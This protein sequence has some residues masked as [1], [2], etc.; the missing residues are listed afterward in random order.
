MDKRYAVRAERCDHRAAPEEIYRTLERITAPLTRSWERL[1]RARRIVI[2]FNMMQPNTARHAGRRQ[3]LVDP[4]VMRAVLRLLR[5]RTGAT[6]LAADT[7]LHPAAG[8][9]P[10]NPESAAVLREFGVELIDA[11]SPPLRF[12]DVPGGGNMFDRYLLTS[13]IGESDEFVSVAKMKNHLFMGV[14][15]CMK[16]L[17]GLP[18]PYRPEGRV[19]HYFHH[20]IRLSYVLPDLAMIADPCLNVIDG[21]V[22]QQGSEWRGRPVVPNALI[23][24]DQT[25]AT[26]ACAARLMGHDPASDWPAPP[27]HRDR[28][29]LLVAAERGYGTVDPDRIDFRTDLQPPLAAFGADRQDPHPVVVSVRRTAC[30]Q[31]LFYRDERERLI[32]R[33]A[34]QMVVLRDRTV[35]WHG[36]DQ[37]AFESHGHFAGGADPGSASFLKMVDPEEKEGEAFAVYE[38]LLPGL[39]A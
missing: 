17:F 15:L 32:D 18:P 8:M 30:E 33:Y 13:C 3:E 19:R 29:H 39:A 26:D 1:E 14:T 31:A 37:P 2:K 21:L 34:G 38:R 6:L 27:F 36:A 22:G 10:S 11:G 20:A 4:E 16:N 35:V 28:N 5:A 7:C 24:G 23:A 25:T 12:Y 9:T